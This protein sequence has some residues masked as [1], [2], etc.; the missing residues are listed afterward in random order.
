[1]TGYFY[2]FA[3]VVVTFVTIDFVWIR[4]IAHGMYAAEI[5][6]LLRKKPKLTAAIAFYV[7]FAAGLVLFAVLPGVA[8][9]SIALTA[10][11]GATLGL[12]AYGTYNLTNLTILQGYTMRIA[13]IDLVWGTSSSGVVAAVATG[14]CIELL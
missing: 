12:V 7:I 4:W 6:H 13:V 1:M 10:G 2:A 8:A 3:I 9:G 11:L 14:I 5:G